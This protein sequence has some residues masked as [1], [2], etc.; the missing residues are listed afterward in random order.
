MTEPHRPPGISVVLNTLD[1]ERHLPYALRSVVGWATE[2]VVVDMASRDRTVDVARRFGARVVPHAPIGWVEPARSVAIGHATQPWVLLLDADELVPVG[3]S[4]RLLAIAARDDVDVVRMP[5]INYLLGAPLLHTGWNPTRE[6][7]ARFFRPG[8]VAMPTRL[9]QPFRPVTG[10]RV[11][12]L[13]YVAGEALVHFNYT[14]V[15]HFVAKLAHYTT[16]EAD[17]AIAHGD[18]TGGGRALWEATREW[19]VR[20]VWHG[21]WRDGWRG[22]HLSLLMAFYRIVVHAKIASRHRLGSAATVDREYQ[23]AAE[24]LLAAYGDASDHDAYASS[25]TKH[26]TSPKCS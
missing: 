11:L 12:D 8:A 3:L 2:I 13:A 10:A 14:D 4:R 24:E 26:S 16:L 9:H 15:D 17:H 21:G 6:M 7:H 18:P 25:S 20:Y 1:E 19:L 5:R 22:F 23:R